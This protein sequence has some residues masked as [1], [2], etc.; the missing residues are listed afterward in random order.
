VKV[1]AVV[2]RQVE[3]LAPYAIKAAR[4]I[5]QLFCT[6]LVRDQLNTF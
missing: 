2:P 1:K 6:T 5:L 3:Q 4:S